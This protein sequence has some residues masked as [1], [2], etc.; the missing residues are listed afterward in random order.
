MPSI[1]ALIQGILS[2]S[3][4]SGSPTPNAGWQN[5]LWISELF[6]RYSYLALTGRLFSVVSTAVAA[7][8]GA[9]PLGAAGTPLAAIY[10]PTGSGVNAIL[11]VC[12]LSNR[13]LG[14]VTAGTYGYSGG[15]T[16]A[17]TA[18][19]STYLNMLSLQSI[20]SAVKPFGNVA[21]TGS[22]ALTAIRP[23]IT[24]GAGVTQSQIGSPCTDEIAGAIIV[25]P[26]NVV[27]VSAAVTG[28]AN[29]VDTGLVWAE[30]PA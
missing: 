7:P 4:K 2:Q 6:P 22:S 26:G 17:I 14:T 18:T 19:P 23:F 10:N 15:P 25:A 1:Q 5:E 28:T 27:A 21:L 8:T 29:T 13:A 16:A 24:T 30:L 12:S 11:V 9:Y 3:Q 20:G